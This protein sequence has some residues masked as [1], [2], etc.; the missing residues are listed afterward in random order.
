MKHL[1]VLLLLLSAACSASEPPPGYLVQI[2]DRYRWLCG[3]YAI[4]ARHIVTAAHCTQYALNRV[5]VGDGESI[6]A[7]MVA[8]W[9]SLDAAI[10][11][12]DRPL[13]LD[14]YAT[15][16]A[17]DPTQPAYAFG[18]CPL[19]QP[20][21]A[22][23]V[24]YTATET[25]PLACNELQIAGAWVCN[26]DSGGIVTQNGAVVGMIAQFRGNRF[27]A[28]NGVNI[29]YATCAVRAEV[30]RERIEEWGEKR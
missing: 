16:Q 8:H 3:G 9:P 25:S 29:A 4:D 5:R 1:I 27:D 22:R 11:E 21:A 13:E 23:L 19:W 14:A 12:T 26:G 15:L 20:T 24:R 6:S 17:L 10:F 18:Y 30:I 28:G 7:A 2:G